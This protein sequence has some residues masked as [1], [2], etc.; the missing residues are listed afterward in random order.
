MD[1]SADE[2]KKA[3]LE[4]D[5]IIIDLEKPLTE[6]A[7]QYDFIFAQM[8]LEHIKEPQMFY[9]N[10]H[11]LLKQ[12]GQAYFFFAC[13]TSL[14]SFINL[15]IPESISEKILFRLQPFRRHEKHG[16][17]KA[18]Y[19]WCFGPTRKN[20]NRFRSLNFV[21]EFY[22]GYFG[23]SYYHRIKPLDF[24]EKVKTK[25]L[26]KHHSPY[27]CSYAHVLLKSE[28]KPVLNFL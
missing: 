20:I 3:G 22:T 23:H 24:L 2:L 16:K 6:S 18:Y 4:Y 27:L 12:G 19:K 26:L 21:V 7:G 25:F 17:F 28:N 8:T 13:L 1:V 10:V 14:P 15:L 5:K 11:K 9:S